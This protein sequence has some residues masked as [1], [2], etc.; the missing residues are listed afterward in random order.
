MNLLKANNKQIDFEKIE[1][2]IERNMKKRKGKYDK[3][4]LDFEIKEIKLE[5]GLSHHCNIKI[6][7][8]IT[9]HRP[10]VGPSLIKIRQI[11]DD[12]I[13][14]SLDPV[15][16][17]QIEINENVVKRLGILERLTEENKIRTEKLDKRLEKQIK[18]NINQINSNIKEIFKLKRKIEK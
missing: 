15:I 13:R 1:S 7:R 18:E 5:E 9:S 6:P 4:I 3:D 12:E 8:R 2:E 17:R 10:I 16:D 11:L 14:L